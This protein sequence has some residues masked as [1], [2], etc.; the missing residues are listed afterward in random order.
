MTDKDLVARWYA[1]AAGECC[2]CTN[3]THD[4]LDAIAERFCKLIWED[5]K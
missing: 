3:C 4:L 2:S 1:M 5:S